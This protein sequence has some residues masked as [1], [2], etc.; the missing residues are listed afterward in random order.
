VDG[1]E[2]KTGSTPAPWFSSILAKGP[3]PR[4][5]YDIERG[6]LTRPCRSGRASI[7]ES[8]RPQKKQ[9]DVYYLWKMSEEGVGI[10]P[11]LAT[12]TIDCSQGLIAIPEKKL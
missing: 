12:T 2:D 6:N 1:V 4:G 7:P 10:G 3:A 11:V 8:R 9:N 5:T